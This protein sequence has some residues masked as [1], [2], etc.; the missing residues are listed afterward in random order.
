MAIATTSDESSAL[1]DLGIG[2]DRQ[3]SVFLT[4]ELLEMA[5]ACVES[6]KEE[7][8]VEKPDASFLDVLAMKD[9]DLWVSLQAIY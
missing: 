5:W 7:K 9:E 6:T 4:P 1:E 2:N 8:L 3:D